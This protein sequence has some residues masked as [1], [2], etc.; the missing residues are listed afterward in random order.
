[1]PLEEGKQDRIFISLGVT[2]NLGNYESVKI[3]TGVSSDRLPDESVEQ[4][5]ERVTKA[6]LSYLEARVTPLRKKVKEI[7]H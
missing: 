2:I 5:Q 1:M 4:A 6:T 3:D 7:I